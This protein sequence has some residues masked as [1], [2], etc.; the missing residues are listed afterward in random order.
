MTFKHSVTVHHNAESSGTF[1]AIEPTAGSNKQ[2]LDPLQKSPPGT[3]HVAASDTRNGD[4]SS[5]IDHS[6]AIS[7]R[8]PTLGQKG[9]DVFIVI[10]VCQTVLAQVEMRLS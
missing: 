5:D 10:Y 6:T 3:S 8:R 2:M 4:I 7:H 9:L 1:D